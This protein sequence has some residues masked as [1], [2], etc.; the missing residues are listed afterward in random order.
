MSTRVVGIRLTYLERERFDRLHFGATTILREKT[1]QQ[2]TKTRDGGNRTPDEKSRT[3]RTRLRRYHS[4]LF[5]WKTRKTK[6]SVVTSFGV[7]TFQYR[8]FGTVQVIGTT[9]Q[10]IARRP[11]MYSV[12]ARADRTSAAQVQLQC[13]QPKKRKFSSW[14]LWIAVISGCC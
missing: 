6:Y 12:H 3:W 14:H 13:S 7:F 5:G 9:G 1:A 2:E 11:T 10:S 8:T 4:N